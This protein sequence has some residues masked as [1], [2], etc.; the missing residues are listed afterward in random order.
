MH[1]MLFPLLCTEIVGVHQCVVCYVDDASTW[2]AKHL[3]KGT[4]LLHR[5]WVVVPEEVEEHLLG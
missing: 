4:K 3:A 1:A 2:V 5:T